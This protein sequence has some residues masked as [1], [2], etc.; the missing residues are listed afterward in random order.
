MTAY[1]LGKKLVCLGSDGCAALLGQETGLYVQMVQKLAPHM[2][3]VWCN[4]HRGQLAGK[5]LSEVPVVE[6]VTKLV[7]AASTHF[8]KSPQRQGELQA[9]QADLGMDQLKVLRDVSTRW[10]SLLRP[11][12]RLFTM[13]T[14]LVLYCNRAASKSKPVADA[15]ELY[16]RL[17]LADNLLGAAMLLPMLRE[18]NKFV[19]HCEERSASPV[20]LRERVATLR[21]A[22]ADMYLGATA[23]SAEAFPELDGLRHGTSILAI[24]AGHHVCIKVRGPGMIIDEHFQLVAVPPQEPGKRGGNRR[25][26]VPM[27]KDTFMALMQRIQ[28]QM[29][30]A[31]TLLVGELDNRF[32]SSA[33]LEACELVTPEYWAS[34]KATAEDVQAKLGVLKEQFGVS[35]E[36]TGLKEGS[37]AIKP[38][39]SDAEMQQQLPEFRKLAVPIAV[40]LMQVVKQ[41]KKAEAKYHKLEAKRKKAGRKRPRT[42]LPW[43]QEALPTITRFWRMLEE[44][45]SAFP[46]ISEWAAAAE[47]VIVM[48]PGSVEEERLFSVMNLLKDDTRNR[49]DEHLEATV[50]IF[51]QQLYT[52]GTFPFERAYRHWLNGVQQGRYDKK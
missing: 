32:P 3:S 45:E 7:G 38:K 2:A 49:L 30:E 28:Q 26:A 52:T 22:V 33:V 41:E 6:S 11:L 24:G 27:D 37:K 42:G 40:Q 21:G 23:F 1:Q 19:K 35:K 46:L 25:H 10:I 31:A 18:L 29:A 4:A 48:V 5:V 51:Y 39:L 47:L 9:C 17:V 13:W 50:R 34:S 43:P 15:G 20:A 8:C 12:E 16:N 44:R 36:R 14:A